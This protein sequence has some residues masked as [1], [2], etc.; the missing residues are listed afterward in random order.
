MLLGVH[1]IDE[2]IGT[3]LVQAHCRLLLPY[4]LAY[5]S[6]CGPRMQMVPRSSFA[7]GR[8]FCI[9]G[10]A[11]PPVFSFFREKSGPLPLSRLPHDRAQA[12]TLAAVRLFAARSSRSCWRVCAT[13]SSVLSFKRWIISTPDR[14]TP[15][16][17]VSGSSFF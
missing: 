15:G 16:P 8:A 17:Y 6:T 7:R 9:A 3:P 12:A 2:Q 5:R 4:R 11:R 1:E 10:A 14:I 13:L